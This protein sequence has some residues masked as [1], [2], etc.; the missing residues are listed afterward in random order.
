METWTRPDGRRFILGEPGDELPTGEL[1]AVVR[2]TD[3]ERRERLDLLGFAVHRRELELL[4]PTRIDGRRPPDGFTFVRA[5][6]VPEEGLRY[7]DDELRQDVPGTAGWHWDAADFHAET[8]ASPH[9]DPAVYLVALAPGGTHAGI[10]R[11]WNRP[12]RPRLGLIG[13]VRDHRRRG[14]A[15]WLLGE[16]FAVLAARGHAEILAEVDETNGA[17]RV[18]LEGLGGRRIGASLELRRP[19]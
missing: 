8:Y 15:R 14:V 5:D 7:L 16:A 19:G 2:E 3:A 10:C 12:E 1:Y 13:V 6:E 18:L 9:F 11:V 17:A 4:L